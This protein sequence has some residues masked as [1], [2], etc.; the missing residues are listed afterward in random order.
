VLVRP[1]ESERALILAIQIEDMRDEDGFV[2][3]FDFARRQYRTVDAAEALRLCLDGKASLH[4]P[5]VTAREQ[6][7]GD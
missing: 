1:P 6:G 3:V 5:R 4:E 7:T 2:W